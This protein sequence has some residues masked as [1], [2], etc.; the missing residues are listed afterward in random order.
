MTY[1]DLNPVRAKIVKHPGKFKWTSF[2][3]YAY[4]KK[5]PL[6]DPAPA[7]LKL[8]RTPKERQ[9]RYREHIEKY[10]TDEGL[11]KRNYSCICAIGNPEWVLPR[12][13]AIRSYFRLYRERRR[14]AMSGFQ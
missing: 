13:E 6:I 14:E 9:Q 1:I 3:F 2:H 10:L 4:G 7:Y 12:Q 11:G 5:D 8:G